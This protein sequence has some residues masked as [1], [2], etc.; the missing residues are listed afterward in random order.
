MN[1]KGWAAAGVAFGVGVEF[2]VGVLDAIGVAA[3]VATGFG[4][5]DVLAIRGGHLGGAAFHQA[6]PSA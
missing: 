1:W 5:A 4:R 6:H 2:D 3:G